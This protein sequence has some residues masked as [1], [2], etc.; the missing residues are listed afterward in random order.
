MSET[1]AVVKITQEPG[2]VELIQS[3]DARVRWGSVLNRVGEGHRYLVSKRHEAIAMLV[4]VQEWRDLQARDDENSPEAR[5]LATLVEKLNEQN[6][7]TAD[8]LDGAFAEL[9]NTREAL[10]QM[11]MEREQYMAVKNDA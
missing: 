1:K 8:A 3:Y 6:K 9:A 7:E 4:P 5:E 2:E 11:R 10:S